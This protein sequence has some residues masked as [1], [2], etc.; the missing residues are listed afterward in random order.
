LGIVGPATRRPCAATYSQAAGRSQGP[1]PNRQYSRRPPHSPIPHFFFTSAGSESNLWPTHA[2]GTTV[3]TCCIYC[4]WLAQRRKKFVGRHWPLLPGMMFPLAGRTAWML[5]SDARFLT[6][7]RCRRPNHSCLPP[8]VLRPYSR[9][10]PPCVLLFTGPHQFVM[11]RRGL[12][13]PGENS[14]RSSAPWQSLDCTAR[15][16]K[17][18]PSEVTHEINGISAVSHQTQAL[19]AATPP[20]HAC[21][22]MLVLVHATADLNK[23]RAGDISTARSTQPATHCGFWIS[24]L[25]PAVYS[26]IA[27]PGISRSPNGTQLRQWRRTGASRPHCQAFS[28]VPVAASL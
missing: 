4:H 13:R 22:A 24:C 15:G 26:W 16:S 27:G 6:L 12:R 19:A 20:A 8:T 28:L 3:P 10:R 9:K 11:P 1:T 25:A 14:L 7:P 18:S 21:S 2:A 23:R 5:D 17:T